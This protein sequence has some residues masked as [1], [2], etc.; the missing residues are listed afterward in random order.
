VNCPCSE[1][2]DTTTPTNPDI[3]AGHGAIPRA[4]E[5]AARRIQIRAVTRPGCNGA[6]EKRRSEEMAR[7]DEETARRGDAF[8]IGDGNP[9]PSLAR[10]FLALDGKGEQWRPGLQISWGPRRRGEVVETRRG[11]KGRVGSVSRVCL[12]TFLSPN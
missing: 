4:P 7:P 5:A 3:P 9:S 6:P 11:G 2:S 10:G 12:F 1:G 8:R